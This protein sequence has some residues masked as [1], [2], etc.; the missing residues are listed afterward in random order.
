M[1]L[2]PISYSKSDIR[3]S[4]SAFLFG[5]WKPLRQKL[6]SFSGQP[7]TQL[8]YSPWKEFF[9][10]SSLNLLCFN[11]WTPSHILSPQ[12]S[13]KEPDSIF[14]VMSSK[15][16]Q[17]VVFWSHWDHLFLQL[18]KPIS[19]SLSSQDECCSSLIILVVLHQFHFYLSRSFLYWESQ[20]RAQHS[21]CSLMSTK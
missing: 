20:N 16:T 18:K 21:R 8:Q 3:M 6:H 9:F 12:I 10:I 2:S 14:L 4:C 15:K 17:Y 11:W 7:P 13:V 5:S 1:S 19:L